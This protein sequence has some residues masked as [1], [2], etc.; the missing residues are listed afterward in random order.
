MMNKVDETLAFQVVNTVK[1]VCGQDIN[2]INRSGIIFAST[3]PERIGE[4]HEIGQKAALTGNT[5]EVESDDSFYGTLKGINMPV[6]YN[7]TFLAVIGISGEPDEVRK[8]VHLAERI[9]SLLFRERE[10]NMTS[11]S[12]TDK[13]H[14]VIDSFIKGT[15]ENME[16]LNSCLKEFKVNTKTDKRLIFIKAET[17]PHGV[18]LSMMEQKITVLFHML[19]ISLFT[20]YYPNEYLAVIDTKSFEKNSYMLRQFARENTPTLKIAVGKSCS[21]YNL[22]DS[23]ISALTALKSIS[24]G[25]EDFLLFD[26]LKLEMILSQVKEWQKNEFLSKT[27]ASLSEDELQLIKAYF[28]ED[29]SLSGTGRRLFLH[30]NTLQYKLNRI[31]QRSGLNPRRFKDA[32][33]LYLALKI[34]E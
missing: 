24:P 34:S 12:Q 9:T 11:R 19:G 27:I 2:F 22:A 25:S 1:D 14:F 28:D 29:M 17:K 3:N 13:R 26:D 16:Y 10:I 21:I 20:F 31:Y 32:V 4:F 5:I 18:N 33:L 6:Y 23:H 30:K 7:N 15:T 8:Y